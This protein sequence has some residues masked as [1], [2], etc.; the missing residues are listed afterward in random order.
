MN[1]NKRLV[2]WRMLFVVLLLFTIVAFCVLIAGSI[3]HSNQIDDKLGTAL[4]I[5]IGLALLAIVL[6]EELVVYM[7]V[8]CFLQGKDFRTWPKTVAY[9]LLLAL[10]FSIIL[11]EAIR[12]VFPYIFH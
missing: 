3:Q 5:P 6:I 11:W 1:A 2:V 7:G 12:F 9:I 8:R 10:D 4:D